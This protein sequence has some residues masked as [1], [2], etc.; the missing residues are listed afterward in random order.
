MLYPKMNESRMCIGMDG[1]WNFK[2]AG[3]EDFPQEWM[4]TPMKDAMTMAVPASYNDQKDTINL[5]SHYGW[6]VYQRTFMLPLQ[7]SGQRTVLRF[8]AVT[9]QAEVWLNGVKLGAHKGGFLPFEFD[10]SGVLTAGENLLCVAVDNRVNYGTLP[11]GN[12]DTIAFFGSDNPGVPSVELAKTRCKPHNRPNFD[13]FNY[14]GITR[15]V[16]LYT[17]PD[18]YIKDISIVPGIEGENGIA[19]YTVET[20]GEGNVEI[21]ILDEN[22]NVVARASGPVGT[23]TIPNAT[24]WQPGKAYL[25]TAH[26]TFGA[27]TYEQTFGIRTVEVRGTQFLIN[28]KPFYTR[29]YAATCSFRFIASCSAIG[30]AGIIV[31]IRWSSLTVLPPFNDLIVLKSDSHFSYTVHCYC[32]NRLFQQVTV[33]FRPY[34]L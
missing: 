7:L 16:W 13:F 3:A 9:H 28:G 12:E 32:C 29:Q 19:S 6:A 14:A 33:Q 1:I 26:V 15:P 30:L 2:I 8:G 11:V 18:S 21:A 20:V 5:R 4:E 17:T 23:C 27:D 22:R 24:L 34:L 25:Y 31:T 10:V